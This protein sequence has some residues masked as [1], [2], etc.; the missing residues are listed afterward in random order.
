M[1]DDDA[2]VAIEQWKRIDDLNKVCCTMLAAL[3]SLDDDDGCYADCRNYGLP[4]GEHS[5]A[6]V[7]CRTAIAAAE[8]AGI[9]EET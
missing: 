1:T 8:A 7:N 5:V 4:K 2:R 6:C 3:K 9:G